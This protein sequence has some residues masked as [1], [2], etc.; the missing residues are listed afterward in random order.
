MALYVP[1]SR[2]R[3]NAFLVAAATL[4]LGLIAGFIVGRSTAITAGD[5]AADARSKGD[6]IATRIQA[7]TIEYDQAVGGGDDS[8]KGGVL[9]ALDLV[10]SDLSKLIKASPWLGT[11]QA[12]NL[13]ASV[14]AVRTAATSKVAADQFAEITK[15]TA[16]FIRDTFGVE[17]N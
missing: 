1:L 9:D 4:L 11:A 12:T 15:T 5:S 10:D 8:I 3:R 6:T 17:D 13:R 2:R 7:L 16:K 14:T